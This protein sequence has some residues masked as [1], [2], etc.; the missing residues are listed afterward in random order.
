MPRP[1]TRPANPTLPC[2]TQSQHSKAVLGGHRL[3][4]DQL[5]QHPTLATS[6]NHKPVTRP[7]VLAADGSG[8]RE[9]SVRRTV[10][11]ARDLQRFSAAGMR[12]AKM[13][14]NAFSAGFHRVV[15]RA[16]PVPLGSRPRVTRYRH[17]R[18]ARFRGEVTAR[19]DRAAVARVQGLDRVRGEQHSP[20]LDVVEAVA[21]SPARGL[22]PLS[23]GDQTVVAEG[24][25][26]GRLVSSRARKG[27]RRRRSPWRVRGP[28]PRWLT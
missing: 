14:A 2:A 13:T 22:S 23:G 9:G 10:F 25:D 26:R 18:A 12:S 21:Q 15:H 5:D 20:D 8:R 24:G 19:P 16:C 11:L 6:R 3:S 28:V 7:S 27:S 1:T 17:F 4:R